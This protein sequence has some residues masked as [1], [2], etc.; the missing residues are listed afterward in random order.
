MPPRVTS[1]KTQLLS[2]RRLWKQLVRHP[3]KG[4]GAD[5]PGGWIYQ[6]LPYM[7]LDTLHEAG[8]GGNQTVSSG[9]LPRVSM[10]LPALYC[11]RHRAGS[12]SVRH[13]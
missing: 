10:A 4:T 6:L 11:A 13:Q 12:L 8:K 9:R 2:Q 5:R 3:N 1:E 7:D